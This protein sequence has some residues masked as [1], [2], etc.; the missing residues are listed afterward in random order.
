VSS[1]YIGL[2]GVSVVVI[3]D[4]GN[5]EIVGEESRTVGDGTGGVSVEHVA[6]A[7]IP[8]NKEK[9]LEMPRYICVTF[10]VG[11]LQRLFE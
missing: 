3:E 9:Y 1:W 7:K 5:A 2:V 6:S 10:M 4:V 8:R 11:L